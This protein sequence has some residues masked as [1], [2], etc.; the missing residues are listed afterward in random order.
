VLEVAT[1]RFDR[2]FVLVPDDSGRFQVAAGGV[3]SYYEFTSPPGER[4]T[5]GEWRAML[6]AGTAPARPSWEEVIIAH[7]KP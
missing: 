5:D 3:Y 6:D 2:I 4:L 1:G 7:A